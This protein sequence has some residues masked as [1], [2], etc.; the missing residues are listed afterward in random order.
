[1][2]VR[3]ISTWRTAATGAAL[4]L[5]T[6]VAGAATTQ[7]AQVTALPKA[8]NA[9]QTSAGRTFVSTNGALFEIKTTGGIK[10]AVKVPTQ[11]SKASTTACFFTGLTEYANTLYATCAENTL[12]PSAPK[13]LLAMDLASSAATMTEIAALHDKGFPNGL[14]SDGAGHLYY[15]NTTLLSAGAVWRITLSGRFAVAEEK[16]FHKFPFCTANG[17][18]FHNKQLYIGANPPTFVGLSQV[19]RYDVSATGLSNKTVIFDSWNVIDDFELV[20]GG[21]VAAEYLAG[22]VTHVSETGQVLNAA[23]GFSSPS[24]AHLV[25]DAQTA[26]RQLLVT[27]AGGNRATWLSTDWGLA[28]R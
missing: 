9:V 1:M 23:K 27:E 28:P 20:K 21:I 5:T 6:A 25:W 15:A 14:A 11:F 12:M 24:S 7:V 22:K 8:E 10:S 19:L 2:Q 17:L 26:Q 3:Q 4:A 16:E 13:H 18:K